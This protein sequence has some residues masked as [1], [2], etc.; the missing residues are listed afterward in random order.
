[1]VI[2]WP[3]PMSILTTELSAETAHRRGS[4]RLVFI[5]LALTALWFILCW[6]L[7]SEWSL[8][9]Q[10]NYGWFVPFFALF[11]FWLRWGD[12][13]QAESRKSKV[14]SRKRI[15]LSITVVVFALALLLPLRLF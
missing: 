7:S 9:E 1:M 14:E 12:R 15:Q 11:L 8:N 10:Y 2:S 3:P 4:L 6:H 5:V 13:P